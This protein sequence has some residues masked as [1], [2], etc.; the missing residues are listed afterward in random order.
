[1]EG[2]L[3]I[4]VKFSKIIFKFVFWEQFFSWLLVYKNKIV[5]L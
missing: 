5:K 2:L 4:F 3:A 1:M